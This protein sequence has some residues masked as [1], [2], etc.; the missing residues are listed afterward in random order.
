MSR[1]QLVSH[2]KT[3]A[4]TFLASTF[5]AC[6]IAPKP[7]TPHT[8]PRSIVQVTTDLVG[9]HIVRVIQHNMELNPLVQFEIMQRADFSLVDTLTLTEVP[10]QGR[11]LSFKNSSGAYIE[12]VE[13]NEEQILIEIEYS[14]LQGEAI[15]LSCTL[16]VNKGMFL[17]IHCDKSQ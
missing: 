9:E 5:A 1:A 13:I 8:L 15:Q 16:P 6:A 7:D 2:I 4:F 14:P 10:F 12:G 3:L 17:K 11:Q